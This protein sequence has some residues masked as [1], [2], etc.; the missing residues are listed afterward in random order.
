MKNKETELY[1]IDGLIIRVPIE[2]I[3]D[4]NEFDIGMSIMSIL[5]KS[6]YKTNFMENIK[7]LGD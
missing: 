2:L 4:R 3:G 6:E 7:R 1:K 5:N